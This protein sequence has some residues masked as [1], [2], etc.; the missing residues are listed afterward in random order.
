LRIDSSS[1]LYSAIPTDP[2]FDARCGEA[3]VEATDAEELAS[4]LADP[5]EEVEC[6]EQSVSDSYLSCARSCCFLS[7]DFPYGA[8]R[9]AIF[10]SIYGTS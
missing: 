2:F 9:I 4:E 7:A 5:T 3:I 6:V 8:M 10:W 1:G